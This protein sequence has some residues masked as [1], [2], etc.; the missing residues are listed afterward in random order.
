M[1]LVPLGST[2][3]IGASCHYLKINGTGVLLDAGVD[4]E[5][6]GREGLPRLDILRQNSDWS[7]DHVIVTHAHHDHLGGLPVVLRE[8]PHARVHMTPAT[9]NLADI[10]LPA[11]ARL[12]KRKLREGSSNR[13]PI[14]DEDEIDMLSYVYEEREL[15]EVF[16]LSG[17]ND[18]SQVTGMLMNSGHILGSAGVSMS[19]RENGSKRTFFFTSDTNVS[20]QTIIPGA[21]YPA[22]VDTL[23]IETTAGADPDAELFSRPEE[24]IRL[25][26]SIERTLARGGAV[27]IP[28]FALGRAQEVL[29]LIQRYKNRNV[30][31]FDTP[32][33]TAGSMRAVASLYDR[34]RNT[35]PR[36]NPDFE[37]EQVS[38]LRLP[39]STS[40]L[41]EAVG[42]PSIHIVASGMMFERTLSNQLATL[43]VEREKNAVF[44]VGYVREDS[45]GG[46]LLEVERGDEVVIS[47]TVG[48]QVVNCDVDRFRLSGHSHR[49]ELVDLVGRLSP[50]KVVLVHGESEAQEWMRDAIESTYDGVD[51]IVPECGKEI[52][53]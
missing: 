27:L 24:E 20:D 3:S 16:D 52:I 12:Q 33:Y 42:E 15:N 7:V 2:E 17:P 49:G 19:F 46:A 26:E 41:A 11:S 40:R 51:V 28:V 36:L 32:V 13:P 6:D 43:M 9:R 37:V 35:T 47:Q 4:P 38:Q 25:G 29:A 45:P 5:H 34:T 30:I 10:L 48:T 14:F 39:R 1:L 50:E 23:L 22:K 31:P 44:F 53:L 21:T 18:K 8:Y